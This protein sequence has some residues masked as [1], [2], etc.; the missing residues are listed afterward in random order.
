[1]KL[2]TFKGGIHPPYNKELTNTSRII[3]IKAGKKVYIPLLQ[4]IGTAC[5]CVVKKGDYVKIGQK[6]GD[7]DAFV[8]SPVH[9][10]VSGT[11]AAIEKHLHP[12]GS[13]I[14]TVIIENDEQNVIY[15]E[16]KSGRDYEK[17]TPEEIIDAIHDA[18]IVGMGGAGFPMHIKLSPPKDKKAEFL[19][20]NGAECEP[21]LSSDHRTMV[22]HGEKIIY[23]IR[24]VMKATGA[25]KAIIAIE[26]NKRDAEAVI[27][28][29]T[30]DDDSI[31]VSVMETKY[32]QGSEKHIIKAVLNREVP[33]GSLPIDVGVIVNNIDTCVAVANAI[34]TGLPVI[35]RRVTVSG[36]AVAH[37]GVFEVPIGM[38]FEEVIEAAGGL[39]DAPRK[40]LMG[41]PM[42]GITQYS[43]DVPVIKTTS[44]ILAL[45][46]NEIRVNDVQP[47]LRCGKCVDACPM[48][49][50]PLKLSKAGK[51]ND[52]ELA[53]EFNALDCIEC[54]S[55]SYVCPA[56]RPL[57]E[58]I[59]LAKVAAK[60]APLE[61]K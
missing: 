58:N 7:S 9:S 45:S 28:E 13:M 38:L 35:N 33:S 20:I 30:C 54:G 39:N 24:A 16:I 21:Y 51:L 52:A 57:I 29:L 17:M 23:G 31:E 42:M 44:G 43:L 2:V 59:R 4:H 12:N 32:P 36:G 53:S 22:E 37:P 34:Q 40:V 46:R 1:M 56:N 25:S 49:L 6:I 26:D 5:T 60:S 50:M 48:N 41:G 19:L 11:V 27:S 55:C 10:S 3:P 61:R 8:S 47:C 14:E 18:G 15:D